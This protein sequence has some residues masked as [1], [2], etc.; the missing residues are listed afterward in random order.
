[1]ID[2]YG[3]HIYR[4][5]LVRSG[6]NQLGAYE[7]IY[8]TRLHAAILGVL[9]GKKVVFMDNSYG[10]NRGFYETWLKDCDAVKMMV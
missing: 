9:L 3:V 5:F 6:V 7:T 10:K 4:P 8:T 1:M 2:F